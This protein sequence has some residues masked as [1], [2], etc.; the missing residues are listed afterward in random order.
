MDEIQAQLAEVTEQIGRAAKDG[1]EYAGNSYTARVSKAHKWAFP[2]REAVIGV[3][4]QFDLYQRAM[5][6]TLSGISGVLDSADLSEEAR[7]KLLEQ[8]VKKTAVEIKVER[9]PGT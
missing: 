2:D 8:A 3:L 5:S 6:L 1:G 4:N 9:K 7:R